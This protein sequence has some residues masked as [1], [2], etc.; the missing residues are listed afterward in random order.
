MVV[1]DCATIKAACLQNVAFNS[2]RNKMILHVICYIF[3]IFFP[4][5]EWLSGFEARIAPFLSQ[6]AALNDQEMEKLGKKDADQYPF[7]NGA[8][9]W[10]V[11]KN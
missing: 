5:N 4:V 6:K 10:S 7:L 11:N 8:I 1:E 9:W 3:V 2:L